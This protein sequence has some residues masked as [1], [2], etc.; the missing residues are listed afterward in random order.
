MYAG[1]NCYNISLMLHGATS[2]LW[3]EER[4]IFSWCAHKAITIKFISYFRPSKPIL[5]FR[6]YNPQTEQLQDKK[7]PRAKPE[8]SMC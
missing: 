7:L 8:S 5:K 4:H 6:N 3:L 2:P 1:I